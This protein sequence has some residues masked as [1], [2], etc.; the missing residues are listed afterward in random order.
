[1]LGAGKLGEPATV[2]SIVACSRVGVCWS[3]LM[4]RLWQCVNNATLKTD[5]ESKPNGKPNFSCCP[6][7]LGAKAVGCG[8]WAACRGLWAVCFGMWAQAVGCGLVTLTCLGGVLTSPRSVSPLLVVFLTCPRGVL[9]APRSVLTACG[10]VST[11]DA[12]F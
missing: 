5:L 1:M 3:L 6:K 9:A 12:V 10:G 4:M 2:C 8:L 11:G 7:G